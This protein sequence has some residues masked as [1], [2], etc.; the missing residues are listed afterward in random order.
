M[1]YRKHL[2]PWLLVYLIATILLF[3]CTVGVI[4]VIIMNDIN[5]F[6]FTPYTVSSCLYST[7]IKLSTYME[8]ILKICFI[9]AIV[10]IVFA[11]GQL[12][13]VAW[14]V[15]KFMGLMNETDDD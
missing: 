11:M 7:N 8:V 4:V 12:L 15:V 3:L 1:L 2:H 14:Q 6:L 10:G 5:G 13:I 9:L